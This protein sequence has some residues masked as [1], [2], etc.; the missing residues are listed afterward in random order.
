M[1][2]EFRE[3]TSFVQKFQKEA[4]AALQ[5]LGYTSAEAARAINQVRDQ[6]DTVDQ[7]IL[8][9]VRQMSSL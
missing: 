3:D 1:K 5:A 2:A 6:A 7:L 9:A 4:Q 8:A